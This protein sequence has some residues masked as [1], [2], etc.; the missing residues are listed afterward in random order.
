MAILDVEKIRQDFPMFTNRVQMQGKP[1]VWLDNS[2]TTFKPR[3]VLE[4]MNRYYEFETSN[5]HRGDYDLSYQADLKIEEARKCVA[6]F[7]GA[8]EKEIVFTSG[9]TGGLNLVAYGYALRHLKEGDEILISQAEHASNVLPWFE[10][11]KL[12]KAKIS[13]VSLDEEGRVTPGNLEKAINEHTKI[14]SLAH[15]GNVLG[16]THDVKAF[17]AIAHQHGAI[18]V[19][20]GAQSAPHM[21]IDVKD[22][23]CDFYVFS[24]HKLCGPT[25]IGALYGK[26]EILDQT[27]PF[28]SGGGMNVKFSCDGQASFLPP[29]LRFEAGT[30]NV[31]GIY[32]LKAAI[33]YL[34]SI[35]LDKIKAHEEELKRYAIEKLKDCP[36]VT[37]YNASS[38]AGIVTFNIEGIF[39]QDAATYFNSK[40]IAVRSGQHCAKMLPSFLNTVATLRASFYF[41]NSTKDIDILIDAINHAE[42]YLDAYFI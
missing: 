15:V 24:G 9:A 17:A 28:L 12:T 26:Y 33:E 1:L 11:A 31:A 36:K 25:G 30:Q 35:G 7:L 8:K 29:P 3:Q 2:S 41:Y 42:D 39:A 10:I 38:E 32:G 23:D 16:Y 4:A 27:A 6:S 21:K 20:D 40:G 22:L 14:V 19:V 18:M 5:S 13:Y 34:Q 37:V